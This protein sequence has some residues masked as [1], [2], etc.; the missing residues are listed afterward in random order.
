MPPKKQ[1]SV[2]SEVRTL[3]ARLNLK[4]PCYRTWSD[5]DDPNQYRGEV[6]WVGEPLAPPDGLGSPSQ[7]FATQEEAE[8]SL[9]RAALK[10]MQEL[11]EKREELFAKELAEA[12]S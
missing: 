10:W 4:T 12:E 2:E 11:M 6:F 1:K 8:G 7:L 3:A 9:A 5:K